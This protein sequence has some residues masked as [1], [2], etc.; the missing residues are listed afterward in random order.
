MSEDKN[1]NAEDIMRTVQN[2]PDRRKF[3]R[4]RSAGNSAFKKHNKLRFMMTERLRKIN[5]V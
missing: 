3:N 1:S 2:K 5:K 4:P